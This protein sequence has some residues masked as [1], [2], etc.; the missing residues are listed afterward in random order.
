MTILNQDSI[1]ISADTTDAFGASV[2][3]TEAGLEK[4]ASQTGIFIYSTN[5][6]AL[7]LKNA[8]GSWIHYG[9]I[10]GARKSLTVPW[11]D[12]TAAFFNCAEASATIHVHRKEGNILYDTTP[13]NIIDDQNTLLTSAGAVAQTAQNYSFPASDGTDGQVLV[14]DGAGNLSFADQSGGGSG[15][16]VILL[17]MSAH[18]T[19]TFTEVNE[20]V[21]IPF[22][23][24]DNNSFGSDVFDT[25]T[26]K[27]T[28]PENGYYY[29]NCSVYQ[30][31]IDDD[32]TNQY[33]VRFETNTEPLGIAFR[34]HFVDDHSATAHTHRLDRIYY[35][36]AGEEVWVTLRNIGNAEND[37]NIHSMR[38][39]TNLAFY[40]LK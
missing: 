15:P 12:Y 32:E 37:S 11:G 21:V 20:R 17:S 10:P 34:N 14:T 18:F 8:A 30:Q 13:E 4:E 9:N 35:L 28:V 27:F 31:G 24:I 19:L 23:T 39:L 25:S 36:P 2:P 16:E 3:T 1:V 33:Q 40:K 22:D 6:Y 7:Y 5:D 26:Y 38:T 29:M